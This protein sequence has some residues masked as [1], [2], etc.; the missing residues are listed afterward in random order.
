MKFHPLDLF[1]KYHT[2]LIFYTQALQSFPKPK[3]TE[4]RS[5]FKMCET[6]KYCFS[7]GRQYSSKWQFNFIGKSLKSYH[8]R[9]YET[10]TRV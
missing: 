2:I 3:E 4:V 6:L 8:S 9:K 10:E 5:T 1:F 7:R